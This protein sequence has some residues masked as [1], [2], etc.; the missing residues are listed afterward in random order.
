MI[1]DALARLSAF[2]TVSRYKYV[3]FGS[4]YFAD[5]SLIHRLLGISDFVSIELDTSSKARFEFN[6]PFACIEMRYGDSLV[7]LPSLNWSSRTILWLD[8]D[9]MISQSV[10]S[11]VGTF[12]SKANS[13]SVMLCTL[14]VTPYTRPRKEEALSD[15]TEKVGKANIPNHLNKEPYLLSGKEIAEVCREIL[16]SKLTRT[17]RDRNDGLN[18][19]KFI[20]KQLFN[21]RYS[22]NAQM[23]T[24]GWL[25]LD[26]SETDGWDRCKFCDFPFVSTGNAPFE[27]S[28]P[29][30]TAR[31]QR[32]FDKFLP[33][34]CPEK[35]PGVGVPV[36]DVANYCNLYRYYP[37][38]ADVEK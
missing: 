26:E 37:N 15:F 1:V 23:A 31:E 3:G 22:D 28:A 11:D 14:N 32:H 5:F 20:A 38:Y 24:Y 2:E 13:G 16:V 8:Y 25:L 30:L 34:R 21:F 10:I 18:S 29:M 7:V 35:V 17:L 12:F 27:I 9:A 4:I 19:S 36:S 33:T 6:K